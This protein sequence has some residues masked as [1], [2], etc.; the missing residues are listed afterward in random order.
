VTSNTE[1]FVITIPEA[2]IEVKTQGKS[3]FDYTLQVVTLISAI[4]VTIFTLL[5]IRKL[6]K[7]DKDKQAQI[8]EL[9]RQTGQLSKTNQLYEKRLRLIHKPRIWSNGGRVSPSKE[10]WSISLDNKGEEATITNIDIISGD[11]ENAVFLIH[12]LPYEL[13]KGDQS[14]FTGRSIG[15]NP[16]D[17]ELIIKVSYHDIEG[18]NYEAIFK[19]KGGATSLLETKEL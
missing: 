18:Y 6:F 1:N 15:K 19:W 3:K 5:S 7:K 9:A 11:M 4:V 17:I 16:N 13:G 2:P 12:A 10:Q 8:D 14:L